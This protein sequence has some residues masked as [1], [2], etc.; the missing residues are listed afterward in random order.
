MHT[1]RFLVTFHMPPLTFVLFCNVDRPATWCGGRPAQPSRG[2]LNTRSQT[3][4]WKRTRPRTQHSGTRGPWVGCS[5]GLFTLKH[6]L[7]CSGTC[8]ATRLVSW[9]HPTVWARGIVKYRG[10]FSF[11]MPRRSPIAISDRQPSQP[12]MPSSFHR[13]SR[14][15]CS[16][17]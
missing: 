2:S 13:Q 14:Y 4:S 1:A 5:S 17:N 10:P 12:R 11:H 15:R 16:K 7:V 9:D 3:A 6:S 8:A